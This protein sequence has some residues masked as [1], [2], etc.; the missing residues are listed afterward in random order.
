MWIAI[1]ILFVVFLA[2]VV[3]FTLSLAKVAGDSDRTI[4]RWR[5]EREEAAP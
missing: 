4:E 3:L 2:V 5:R 1:G